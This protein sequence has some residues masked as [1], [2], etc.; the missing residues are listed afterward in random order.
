VRELR[1][2]LERTV[3]LARRPHLLALADCPELLPPP[4]VPTALPPVVPPSPPAHPV[5][6]PGS[7]RARERRRR[8]LDLFAE[9]PHLYAIEAVRAL[10]CAPRT[11]AAD[12]E[13]LAAAGLIR[14]VVTS[15]NLGTSYWVRC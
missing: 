11:C 9:H 7:V 12:L 2:V 15:A 4:T 8:L 6:V 14:R 5:V 1:N 3:I 10:G 13:A